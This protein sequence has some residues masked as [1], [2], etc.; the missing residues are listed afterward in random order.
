MIENQVQILTS[1]S[2]SARVIDK[3][4]LDKDPQFNTALV[5]PK[6]VEPGPLD[7]VKAFVGNL[8][9]RNW[10]PAPTASAPPT[11]EQKAVSEREELIDKMLGGLSVRSRGLSTA[12]EISYVS[13]NPYLATYLANAVS[14]AY[15]EDQLNAKYEASQKA[16][17]WLQD[18]I[19]SLADQVRNADVAVQQYKAENNLKI[20]RAH[21]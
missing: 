21:V 6:P 8:N 1:R 9:P 19:Q 4:H 2:L 16:T 5:P 10:L 12:I 7:A 20:G 17:V 13:P 3:L 18:R 11:E 15:V 14:D